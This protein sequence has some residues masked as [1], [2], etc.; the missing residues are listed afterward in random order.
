M[1]YEEGSRAHDIP[2]ESIFK[3]SDIEF[4][5]VDRAVLY[6][7]IE[8]DLSGAV[9]RCACWFHGR[10]YLADGL[11]S[12][13][14]LKEAMDLTNS[15][16]T[17]EAFAKDMTPEERLAMRKKYSKKIVDRLFE[18][19]R[20]FKENESDYGS[21]V[22]RGVNYLLDD[23]AAFRMFLTDGRNLFTTMQ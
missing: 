7:T 17:I 16:F 15:L 3:D 5:V 1:L 23:E 18:V 6:E 11:M 14:R 22:N 4:C 13:N 20:S 19:L 9:K 2:E 8:K 12:D 21:L 10:H